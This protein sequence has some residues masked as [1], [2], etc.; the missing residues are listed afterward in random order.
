MML[1]LNL[2]EITHVWLALQVVFQQEVMQLAKDVLTVKAVLQQQVHVHPV[3]P[4][5]K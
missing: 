3:L 4:V 2:T 5:M 1:V